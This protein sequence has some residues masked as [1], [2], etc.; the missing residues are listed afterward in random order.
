MKMIVKTALGLMALLSVTVF[1]LPEVSAFNGDT[2]DSTS[3]LFMF[4]CSLLVFMVAPA[5]ALFYGGMLRKQ[6]MTWNG[7]PAW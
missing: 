7:S 5:I 6:S 3:A 1:I 4:I 2:V